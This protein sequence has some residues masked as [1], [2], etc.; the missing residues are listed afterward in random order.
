[1]WQT[2]LK[3]LTLSWVKNATDPLEVLRQGLDFLEDPSKINDN[4]EMWC[5]LHVTPALGGILGEVRSLEE[6]T[7]WAKERA[8]WGQNLT[9]TEPG[10]ANLIV[11]FGV[12]PLA[13][14]PWFGQGACGP[15]SRRCAP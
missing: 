10:I 3:L 2:T 7:Y 13:S 5:N 4:R 14:H 6:V 12:S 1:M 9:P 11:A 15:K 8:P